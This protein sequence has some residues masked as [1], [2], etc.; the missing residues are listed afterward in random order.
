MRQGAL[1][2]SRELRG[3][4]PGTV[5]R[6][7]NAACVVLALLAVLACARE[8]PPP[9]WT[10]S[11]VLEA[12]ESG[13]A[14]LLIGTSIVDTAVVWVSGARGTWART[15]DGGATWRTGVVPGADSLQ[16]R[17]VHAVDAQNAFLLS[18]GNGADSRIYRTADGG[19]TWTLQFRNEEPRAFFDCFA[20]WDAQSG[21]AFSDSFDGRF[22]LL[23]TSDGGVTWSPIPPEVLP[24]AHEGEGAF[25]ASGT[26]VVAA[27]DGSAWI[28]TGASANGAR[29]LRTTD[30]GR[31][32]SIAETP[33]VKGEAAGIASL[34]F[35][36][37]LHGAALGGDI[38]Q[39]DA[40][41][42]NVAITRDGGVTWELAGRPPFT[43][44]VYGSSWVPGAPTP[45]LVAVGPRG[46]GYSTDDG[47]SWSAL[48]T[49]NHW[50]VAFAAPD[51]GWAVGPN[52]RITRIRLF[53][54]E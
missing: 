37:A 38:A 32:W 2:R 27:G 4:A 18:I 47:R 44:A 29:V 21:I 39:P 7:S 5:M 17:D 36:D 6:R 54:Q 42:D 24:P 11:P 25:A 15:V 22:L 26:C 28:G 13:T 33:I 10:L 23:Q 35:R 49:L 45:T 9:A 46:L 41:T 40:L 53:T 12:Q 20:F 8:A 43:G 52:G 51:R 48:D 50:G 19:A 30:R 3:I 16:F 34:A 1:M 31:T 14:A